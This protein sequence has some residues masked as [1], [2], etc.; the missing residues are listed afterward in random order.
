MKWKVSPSTLSGKIIVPP[1]KSHTIRALLIAAVADGQSTIR[2]LLVE[3]DGKSALEGARKFGG[4]WTLDGTTLTIKGTGGDFN[5]GESLIDFGNS[6]TSTR[7]FTATAAL[8]STT[9]TIDG[10]NSL[11]TRPMKPL[12]EALK[13]LGASYT[14]DSITGDIPF[15]ITG[16]I[17]G[18]KTEI[19]GVTSQFLSA[20]L[21]ATPLAEGNSEITL[22][23]LNEQPYVEM[24]LWWLDKMGIR[25]TASDDLLH[26][27]VEGGQRYAPL[28][29]TIPGDFSSATFGAVAAGVSKSTVHLENIDFTDPQGDKAI[30]SYL[31]KMGATVTR[32]ENGATVSAEN[33]L[34]G[35]VLDL[36]ATP[37]ALPA[38][39]VLG[40]CAEG[41]T[42]IVN[43]K[44]ARIKETDRI[45]VMCKE[46]TK[47]GARVEEHEDGLTVYKSKLSGTEVCGHH[48]HRVVMSLTLAGS[49]ATGE[50][51][52]D[53][54][55]S[56]RVT[57]PTFAE[58]FRRIGALINEMEK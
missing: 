34:T 16:P 19:S 54:A 25:Y 11:R 5:Q 22:P 41:K 10:D 21:I 32:H 7:L 56:A 49:V 47:M 8:G 17:Q 30:F 15:S 57:Y 39:A 46:L 29:C 12:L 28:D 48:D 43:V 14:I 40:T 53:T 18:G 36:N 9:R 51:I 27:T 3:G 26:Y 58:D 55:E 13:N 42:S 38:F 23:F 20:L 52:I 50:T 1:S 31:E 37:D 4:L 44:Q 35:V 6:G 33:G 45:D 2:S 24:T